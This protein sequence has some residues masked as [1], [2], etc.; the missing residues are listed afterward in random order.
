MAISVLG[1]RVVSW[2]SVVCCVVSLMSYVAT[3]PIRLFYGSLSGK[4]SFG[5]DLK[6]LWAGQLIVTIVGTISGM[7]VMCMARASIWRRHRIFGFTATTI[8]IG[9][10]LLSV[11]L[12]AEAKGQIISPIV[13]TPRPGALF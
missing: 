9:S 5:W 4:W 10:T 7:A 1:F 3:E 13:G 2:L 11:F 8:L 12:W 6:H